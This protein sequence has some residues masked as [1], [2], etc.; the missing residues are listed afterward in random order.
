MSLPTPNILLSHPKF[1]A[2]Y[3]GQELALDS[4]IRWLGSDKRFLCASMPTGS[5]KSLLAV[6]ASRLSGYRTAILTVTKGLQEQLTGD[7][8]S[9][10]MVDIRGQNSYLCGLADDGE[11]SVEDGACHG[12]IKCS[13][14]QSGCSYYDQVRTAKDSPLLVTNYAYYLAQTGYSDGLGDIDLLVC[15]EAHLA[16]QALESYLAFYLGQSETESLGILPRGISGWDQWQRWAQ[17]SIPTV[18]TAHQQALSDLQDA[19]RI[20]A[21]QIRRVKHY[22]DLA[23]RLRSLA[24]AEGEWIVEDRKSGWRFT[25]IWP[26][27][28]S[29]LLYRSIPKII[30]MSATLSAKTAD[31][32]AIP[33]NNREW[34]EVPS[35]FPASNSPVVSIRTCRVDHRATES[36]MATWVNRIDQ[37]IARR[38]DRKG[39][40]FTVSYDRRNYLLSQ[41]RFANQL[42]AHGKDDVY[43]VVEDFKRASPPATLISPT[44]TSGWDF[45]G[46][47]CEYVVVGKIPYPDTRDPV[48][49]ARIEGDREWGAYLAMQT[50]VQEAGRGT[51]SAGD[52]CEYLVVDDNWGQWFWRKYRH[53]A[54]EWFGDRVR[55]GMLD[56]VPEPL[57]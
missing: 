13:L 57:V 11:T 35:Y 30:V 45:P 22:G 32:L 4:I 56:I 12:G 18:D 9:I 29:R 25:P 14:K 31:S 20:T 34:L 42:Y 49:K 7:F 5:G 51:R 33:S 47:D 37:I 6:L 40:V 52:R 44:V 48:V 38:Q 24:G 39:I 8:S 19:T 21:Y 16:F 23:R 43:R 28:Q 46:A 54:P 41:S 15:D 26:G 1:S 55:S 36:D 50:L 17:R 27:Q 2:W 10:G 3:P 53:F